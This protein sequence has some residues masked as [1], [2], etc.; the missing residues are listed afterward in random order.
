ML[1][2]FQQCFTF[3][4]VSTKLLVLLGN[5]NCFI[6]VSTPNIIANSCNDI[7]F[8]DLDLESDGENDKSQ[9]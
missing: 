4:T 2:L 7:T 1:L 3:I 6:D 9:I 5:F 8:G